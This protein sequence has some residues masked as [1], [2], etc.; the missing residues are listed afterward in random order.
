MACHISPSTA[1]LELLL[2]S[3]EHG[4]TYDGAV[5]EQTADNAHDHCFD[6]DLFRVRQ[7]DWQSCEKIMLANN[8][9]KQ[10]DPFRSI[11]IP[12]FLAS[13]PPT[14]HERSIPTIHPRTEGGP[15]NSHND[16]EPSQKPPQLNHTATSRIH[17]V[18]VVLSFAAYPVGDGSEDVGGH[19]EEGEVVV[20]Q[21]RREDDEDE[22]D[23]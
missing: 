1:R 12:L 11:H 6:A 7:D 21:G 4:E 17:E 10:N 13:S 2:F 14:T 18:I 3:E 8:C 15:T 9:P 23:G 5:D 22:A 16:K 20:V 19:D